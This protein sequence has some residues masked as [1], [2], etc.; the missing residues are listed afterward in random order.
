MLIL[1]GDGDRKALA[2]AE[3]INK[4]IKPYHPQPQPP[5]TQTFFYG[6]L[7][8]KLEGGKLF[9][10]P[11]LNVNAIIAK[12][13]KTCIVDQNYPWRARKMPAG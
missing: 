6:T 11:D 7:P 3:R 8:T 2:D 10:A 12:F 1:V 4:L 9:K 5:Q 13:L